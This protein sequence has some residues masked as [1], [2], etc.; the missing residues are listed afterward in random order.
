MSPHEIIGTA[1][2][3]VGATYVAWVVMEWHKY[4]D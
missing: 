1:I 2:C 3:V 4:D